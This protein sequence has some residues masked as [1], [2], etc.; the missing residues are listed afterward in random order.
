VTRSEK[1]K[2]RREL[3][4]K[5]GTLVELGAQLTIIPATRRGPLLRENPI[6]VDRPSRTCKQ[7]AANQGRKGTGALRPKALRKALKKNSNSIISVLTKK[8]GIDQSSTRRD[9]RKEARSDRWP[10]GGSQKILSRGRAGRSTLHRQAR[11]RLSHG[12]GRGLIPSAEKT[13]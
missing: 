5:E 9:Y 12:V 4:E 13:C 6:R 1:G 7:I 10:G 2:N 11:A 8:A 3:F